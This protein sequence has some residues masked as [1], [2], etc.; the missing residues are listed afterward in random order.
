MS[1]SDFGTSSVVHS[2]SSLRSIHDVY[3][4][5]LLTVTFTTTTFQ[6]AAAYGCLK[7]APTSRLRRVYPHLRHSTVSLDTFLTQKGRH[8]D[9]E[10]VI[11]C[12]RRYLRFKLSY[13]DLVEMMAERGLSLAHTTIMRRVHSLAVSGVRTPLEPVRL[14]SRVVMACRRNLR[15]DP[16]QV[17]VPVVGRWTAR[18]RRGFPAERQAR[19]SR[20]G[21]RGFS[22]RP[23]R[24]KDQLRRPLH[25]TVTRRH[26]APCAR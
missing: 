8:F 7:P 16:R 24:V 6:T 20:R 22:A 18:V 3:I 21:Q 17:G 5:R 25:L 15:E 2:R 1:Q 14:M 9:R 10:V 4:A 23:S 19:Q 11:L 13:H 12:V 26:T